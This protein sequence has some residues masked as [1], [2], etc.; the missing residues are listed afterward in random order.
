MAIY[1]LKQA[2][3]AWHK[4]LD[5]CMLG[6][7]YV[8]SKIEPCLYIKCAGSSKPIVTLH[9]GDFFVFSNDN[10]ESNNLKIRLNKN[11][12]I[13]DL[14]IVKECLGMSVFF[15]KQNCTVTLSQSSQETD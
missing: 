15:D 3:R 12:V 13:K 2:S 6:N 4:K 5:D 9:V 7:G 8:K 14:G 1:G 11:F 10:N